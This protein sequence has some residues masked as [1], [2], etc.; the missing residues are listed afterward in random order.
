MEFRK[1]RYVYWRPKH[2]LIAFKRQL[3][4][5]MVKKYNMFYKKKETFDEILQEMN[6]VKLVHNRVIVDGIERLFVGSIWEFYFNY[7]N[8]KTKKLLEFAIDSG[9][10]ERNS[11]GFGFVNPVR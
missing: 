10:G 6:F 4:D 8:P 2:K 1:K 11:L 5:N 9:L 3:E 7:L